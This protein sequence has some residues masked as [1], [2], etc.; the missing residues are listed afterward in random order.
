MSIPTRL[1]AL[2]LL[3]VFLANGAFAAPDAPA[4]PPVAQPAAPPGDDGA[5]RILVIP[6]RDQVDGL[7]RIV[8][9]KAFDRARQD[10]TIKAVVIDMNTPGGRIDYMK[11]VIDA[12]RSC[13]VPVYTFVNIEASS[14]GA[15]IA[16]GTKGI[17]MH[18][19][20]TIGSATPIMIM[21]GGDVKALPEDFNEKML[22][23]TRSLVRALAQNNGYLP[24]LAEAFVDRSVEVKIGERIVSEKGKL[25]SLTALEAVEI[26]PPREI[27][28]LA[29]AVAEDLEGVARELGFPA[30][31]LVRV[32]PTDGER[33]ARFLTMLAPLLLM[34]AL[35][36]GYLEIKTPGFGLPGTISIICFGLYLSGSHI[37]GFSSAVEPILIILGVIL[38]LVEIFVLPGF[39]VA[40][41]AGIVCLV[42][43][44]VMAM[45][46]SVPAPPDMPD[47][48][49]WSVSVF[50]DYRHTAL[51][52]FT[53]ALLATIGL[54][55]LLGKYL[56]ATSMY[57]K[58]VLTGAARAEDGF[59]GLDMPAHHRLLGQRGITLTDLRPAGMATIA[60]Q[61][62]D[63]VSDGGF[64]AKGEG[65]V[66]VE[67]NGPR[68]AVH[69]A[70][71]AGAAPAATPPASG[72][73]QG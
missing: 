40:G 60:G 23:N 14:A 56:P 13:R 34:I 69:P 19:A 48:P 68:I 38:I 7:L 15:I 73:R 11:E 50:Q 37:A 43:G 32:E 59:V 30:T 42:V 8:I 67:V 71:P 4:A 66:V 46:P 33:L 64:I 25:L 52:N 16:L 10:L 9:R 22:S 51:V 29:R 57:S 3:A 55:W 41:I 65:I 27:P 61:R 2:L 1:T 21:P 54:G 17:F 49:E 20:A 63:V 24:D 35:A 18:P 72:T 53:V 31:A 36:A 62:V 39:G 44:I 26:I 5:G 28:L 6:L 58:L 70:P 45:V 12:I 47:F